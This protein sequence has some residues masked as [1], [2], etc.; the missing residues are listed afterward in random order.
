MLRRNALS[1]A[2]RALGLVPQGDV[3]ARDATLLAQR[4]YHASAVGALGRTGGGFAAAAGGSGSGTRAWRLA[5]AATV[6]ALLV[7]QRRMCAG[8]GPGGS[9]GKKNGFQNFYPKNKQKA[10]APGTKAEKTGEAAGGSSNKHTKAEGG[11]GGTGG[12]SGGGGGNGEKPG[13]EGSGGSR[14]GEDLNSNTGLMAQVGA[15]LLLSA[16]FPL[17]SGD[18]TEEI[19]F[20]KFRKLLEKGAVERLEVSNKDKVKVFV[21]EEE[22]QRTSRGGNVRNRNGVYKYYFSIGSIEG[23]ENRL[24]D[25]QEALGIAPRDFLPVTYKTEIDWISEAATLLPVLLLLGGTFLLMRSQSGLGGLG[26]G[27]GGLGGG[28]GSG[29]IFGVSKAPITTLDPKSKTKVMFKDVAGCDEAKLEIEEFVKFLK[30]PKKYE[31]LGAKLPRGALLVGPPGTGK[32]LLAKATAGEAGVPFLSISGS[33][34]TEM[35]VGVGAARVRDLFAQARAQEPSIVF[36][37]EIDAVGRSRKA[38][39]TPGSNEERENTLNQLLVEMDG[40]SGADK[41][42]VLAATNRLDSLDDALLRPGRLDRHVSVGY[43]DLKGRE[44]ILRVHLKKIK[45]AQNVEKLLP[46]LAARTPGMAGAA[47]ANVVNEAAVFAVRNGRA[48]VTLPD[49]ELA[50]DRQIGGIEKK[51]MVLSEAERKVI[52]YHEAGHAVVGWFLQH[53]E[54]LLRVSIVPRGAAALGYAQY[55]P[56]ETKVPTLDHFKDRMAVTLGGRAAETEMLGTAT[57]GAQNDLEKVKEMA[58]DA[59]KVYGF[60]TKAGL[61]SFPG[62]GGP[63]SEAKRAV[64]DDEAGALVDLCWQRATGVVNERKV[65]VQNLAE[66]LLE[67][68]V[69]EIEDLVKILGERPFPSEELTNLDKFRAGLKEL[70]EE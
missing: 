1:T 65:E 24:E 11:G 13:G 5:N 66:R 56:S 27:G 47:I 12:G 2:T 69:I 9:G 10:A 37:D 44:A 8:G 29:G 50:I 15:M 31:K 35:F 21:S 25:A 59:V 67:Q 62:R 20:Q 48:A 58:Y 46:V 28:R 3:W 32:T 60:S 39:N 55:L 18:D 54:P 23:F 4:Y 7:Q 53:A 30:N 51:S 70:D 63:E 68:S 22:A 16:S 14:F 45:L 38:G 49:F 57:T 43:P 6:E 34:F 40:F 17:L 41:V 33:D 61:M 42:V 26:R 19:S 36:I 64:L 52:A